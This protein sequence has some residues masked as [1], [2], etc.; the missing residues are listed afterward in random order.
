[1]SVSGQGGNLGLGVGSM[2]SSVTIPTTQ[3][4]CGLGQVTPW[5]LASPTVKRHQYYLPCVAGKER[6]G[7]GVGWVKKVHSEM[8]PQVG[9]EVERGGVTG[10]GS[11]KLSPVS[12]SWEGEHHAPSL[13][14]TPVQPPG[15]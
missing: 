4:Q 10:K 14:P 5:A 7:G 15:R 1:M 2:S 8:R 13:R 9:G 3:L 6:S 11:P 12:H